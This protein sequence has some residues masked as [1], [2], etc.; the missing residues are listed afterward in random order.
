M[1]YEVEF[2]QRENGEIPIQEFLESLPPK[3]RAKTFREIELLKDHGPDLRE[4]H[5]KPI[6]G[7][8][9]NGIFELRVKFSTNIS[10]LFY[11]SYYENTFVLLH[12]FVKKTNK[13][14]KR[15]IEKAKKY[16]EDYERRCKDE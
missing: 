7:K 15:E 2:Y 1:S 11:F 8:D 12:G 14:P 16:K 3:L 5:T 4:P 13:T 10:R 9:N 6:K